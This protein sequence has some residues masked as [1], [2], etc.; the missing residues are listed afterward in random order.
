MLKRQRSE[1]MRVHRWVVGGAAGI[2]AMGSIAIAQPAVDAAAEPPADAMSAPAGLALE[3]DADSGAE[4]Y[5]SQCKGCHSVS[6]APTLRG[7][8]DRPIGSDQ[9]FHGYSE[10]LKTKGGTWTDENLDAFLRA[11]REFAPGTRMLVSNG[12]AQ[13]R[14][15]IIAFIRTL[16]P[17]R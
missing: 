6:I 13:A 5:A 1:R 15:D 16:P 2:V 12:D 7:V 11:P 4:L 3:G 10:A 9:E 14:A 17:K 8:A